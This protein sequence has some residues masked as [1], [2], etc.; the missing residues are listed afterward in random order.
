MMAEMFSSGVPRYPL[1][2]TGEKPRGR[3]ASK[4]SSVRSRLANSS[5][6]LLSPSWLTHISSASSTAPARV[7]FKSSSSRRPGIVPNVTL[8]PGVPV[9]SSGISSHCHGCRAS[10]S[11]SS[12]LARLAKSRSSSSSSC[13]RRAT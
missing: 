12:R 5:R 1:R 2:F 9:Y 11:A 8:H 4:A 6:K 7:F 13:R 3:R 10:S